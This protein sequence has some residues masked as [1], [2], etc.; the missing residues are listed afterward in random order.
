MWAGPFNQAKQFKFDCGLLN[1]KSVGH[2][3]YTQQ[4]R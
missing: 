4:H 3:K 1:I 2:A